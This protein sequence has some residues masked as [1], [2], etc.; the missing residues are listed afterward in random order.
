MAPVRP[1]PRA[2]ASSGRTASAWARTTSRRVWSSEA[3]A[4]SSRSKRAAGTGGGS[5]R[6]LVTIAPEPRGD[7]SSWKW[8]AA[9][10]SALVPTRSRRG[11]SLVHT[12]F[13]ARA[14]GME[15]AAGRDVDRARR[16]AFH[17]RPDELDLVQAGR[18][19]EQRAGVGMT[20]VAEDRF[21]IALLHDSPEVHDRRHGGSGDARRP[22]CAR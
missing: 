11:L 1:S 3:T 9:K 19:R 18:G 15:R 10:C 2:A 14:A 22:G 8:Q 6:G 20:R 16:L 21:A 17:H 12:L 4:R 5:S 7:V 13:A